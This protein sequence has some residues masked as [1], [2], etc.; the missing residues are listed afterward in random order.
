MDFVRPVEAVIPGVQGRVLGVLTRT[1][2]EMTMRTVAS[3]AGVSPNRA[4]AL[5]NN[6][7]SL[8][9]VERRD[10]GSSALVRLA[11]DN[12]A[13]RAILALSHVNDTMFTRL[14]RAATT[15]KPAPT[16]LAIFG[17]FARGEA[18]ADSDLDVLAVRPHDTLEDDDEWIDS[19]GRWTTTARKI[20]GNPVNVI[21]AGA[22]EIPQ[23]LAK[24]H[25]V[26]ESIAREGLTLIGCE[27]ATLARRR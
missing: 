26:W 14:R 10:A 21:E 24:R 22:A 20:T 3:V 15:I 7:A 6:L 8:G 13:A 1:E 9:I 2:A 12:E 4:T 11:R 25:S 18:R 23:L 19:I 27:I 17:S 16:T 5:L